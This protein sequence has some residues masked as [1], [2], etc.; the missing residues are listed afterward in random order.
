MPLLDKELKKISLFYEQQ[1]KELASDI[2]E[3][4][5]E[6]ELQ[7]RMGLEAGERYMDF[8]DDDDDDD[9]ESVSRSPVARY[10]RQ[11]RSTIGASGM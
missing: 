8:P 7:E 6:V 10:R 5:E 4:E 11:R 2:Q 3:L 1:E 9:D